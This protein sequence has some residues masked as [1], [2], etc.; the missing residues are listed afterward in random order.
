[1]PEFDPLEEPKFAK[2]QTL[3][4]DLVHDVRKTG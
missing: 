3:I 1:M 4:R 2:M